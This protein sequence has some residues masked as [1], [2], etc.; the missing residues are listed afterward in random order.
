M[1]VTQERD[2][3]R[4]PAASVGEELWPPRGDTGTVLVKEPDVE[5]DEGEARGGTPWVRGEMGAAPERDE[6]RLPTASMVD[7]ELWT[8]RDDDGMVLEEPCV[9]SGEGEG[10]DGPP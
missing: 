3:E 6:E 4:L 5:S 2:E 8:P 7:D 10:E 9:E 1:G